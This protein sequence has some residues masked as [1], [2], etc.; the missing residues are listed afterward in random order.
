MEQVIETYLRD[1]ASELRQNTFEVPSGH[2]YFDNNFEVI[3]CIFVGEDGYFVRVRCPW[4]TC[5]VL[6]LAKMSAA[7]AAG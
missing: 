4:E 1:N 2:V 6:F 7:P 3:F 5:Q